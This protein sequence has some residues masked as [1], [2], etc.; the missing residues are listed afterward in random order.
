MMQIVTLAE[1][2]AHARIDESTEDTIL[3][4]YGESAEELVLNLCN[5]TLDS[6]IEEYGNVPVN[7]KHAVLMLVAH[8]YSQRQ[9][10]SLQNLYTVP[11]TLD[12]LIKPYMIL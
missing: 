9:P 6:I 4:T 5:R 3:T 12:A 2:K 8:S 7:I 1:I 11:Y 10:A